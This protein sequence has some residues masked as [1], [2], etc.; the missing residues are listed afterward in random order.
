MCHWHILCC[1]WDGEREQYSFYSGSPIYYCRIPF[2]QK[3]DEGICAEGAI[4]SPQL[5]WY[6]VFGTGYWFRGIFSIFYIFIREV[7]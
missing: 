2:D 3:E 7:I 6:L 5:K 4:V 1:L